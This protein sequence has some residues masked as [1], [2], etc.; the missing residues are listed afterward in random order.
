MSSSSFSVAGL[1][2]STNSRN[3][4]NLGLSTWGTQS[5]SAN[6]G[7]S[8]LNASSSLADSLSQ[9]RSQYQSGYLMVRFQRVFL[10]LLPLSWLILFV[11]LPY[12]PQFQCLYPRLRRVQAR[13]NRITRCHSQEWVALGVVRRTIL[14][15]IAPTRPMIRTL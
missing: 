15:E 14:V 4:S 8:S 11:V 12:K 3:N 13:L 10:F 6:N 9:S 7:P 2:G 1:A 5:A